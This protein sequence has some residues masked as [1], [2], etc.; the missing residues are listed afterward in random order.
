MSE[1]N[2]QRQSGSG[3]TPC[4][5]PGGA[6][7]RP[8]FPESPFIHVA[9]IVNPE[10]GNT[11]RED[12]EAKKHQIPIGNLVEIVSDSDDDRFD[13][14]RLYVVYHHRDCDGTP[15]YAMAFDKT[16]TVQDDPRFHNRKWLHGFPEKSIRV[17]DGR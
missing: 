2:E 15:L 5:L 12:N 13:G 1:A 16:D 8:R 10:T 3:S 14:V 17:V 9:D 11:Y 4:C 6:E 7:Y